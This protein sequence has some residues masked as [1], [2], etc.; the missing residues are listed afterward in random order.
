MQRRP[1]KMGR[2]NCLPNIWTPGKTTELEWK[3]RGLIIRETG[4]GESVWGDGTKMNGKWMGGESNGNG[5][6]TSHSFPFHSIYGLSLPIW[7]LFISF[8]LE[9]KGI[10]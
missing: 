8:L 9:N 5:N 10:V 4:E 2:I 3:R 6:G 1:T 7:P